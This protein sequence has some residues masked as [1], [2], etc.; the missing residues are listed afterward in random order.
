MRLLVTWLL[1][2]SLAAAQTFPRAVDPARVGKYPALAGSG[3]GY[4]YDD[5]LEYRVW[6]KNRYRAFATF[7]EARA[8]ARR[9]PG[10]EAPLVLVRQHEYI[11]E[12]QPGKRRL[13]KKVR[14]TEWQVHWLRGARRTPEVVRSLL[15]G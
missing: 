2:T 8:Y 7:E 6:T 9:T 3:G 13:C 1:F 14:V 12:P 10:S 5:V 15:K 4:V 11:D